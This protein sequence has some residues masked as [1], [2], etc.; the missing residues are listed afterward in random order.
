MME[1][2]DTGCAEEPPFWLPPNEGPA[3]RSLVGRLSA[4]RTAKLASAVYWSRA[5]ANR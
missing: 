3:D 4:C 5:K 2:A 1:P